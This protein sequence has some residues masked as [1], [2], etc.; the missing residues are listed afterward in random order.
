VQTKVS[1][2][3]SIESIAQHDVAF[4]EYTLRRFGVP[5]S[6]V[7]DVLQEV[8]LGAYRALPKYQTSRA[9]V[10]TWLYVI[11]RNHAQTFLKRAYHHREELVPEPELE[12]MIDETPGPEQQA[13]AAETRRL[14][15]GLIDTLEIHRRSV[16]IAYELEGMGILEIAATRGIPISTGW[17]QLVQARKE[18][19]HALRRWLLRH[20][21]LEVGGLSRPERARLARQRVSVLAAERRWVGGRGLAIRDPAARLA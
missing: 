6:D 18:L 5:V 14:V 8:L 4:I 9:K 11:T 1:R 10:R 3:T 17:S 16:L 12:A 13:I 19:G 15:L 21:P 2:E 7:E 20:A